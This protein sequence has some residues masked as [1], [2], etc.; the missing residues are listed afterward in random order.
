MHRTC[1]PLPRYGPRLS[2]GGAAGYETQLTRFLG[3]PSELLRF[4]H[5]FN[6]LVLQDI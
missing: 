6:E 1:S 3:V 4:R 2:H 5:T